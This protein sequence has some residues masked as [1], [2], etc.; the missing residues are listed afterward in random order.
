MLPLD[1][2]IEDKDFLLFLLL[3]F[4]EDSLLSLSLEDDA[5]DEDT[6]TLFLIT[7]FGL[8]NVFDS[9]IKDEDSLV[10]SWLFF[11]EDSLLELSLEVESSDDEKIPF[12]LPAFCKE[13]LFFLDDIDKGTFLLFSVFFCD[14]PILSLS[15]EIGF[16][17]IAFCKDFL[18][19]P[20][21]GGGIKD[22]G[23]F[24]LLLLFSS[25]SN[26][27]LISLSLEVDKSVFA[28]TSVRE[29]FLIS[30]HLGDDACNSFLLVAFPEDS[31]LLFELF[32]PSCTRVTTQPSLTLELE[33]PPS[34]RSISIFF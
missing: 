32:W 17:L 8:S 21:L 18:L 12:L 7:F 3:I 30:P 20:T 15:L 5:T 19:S 11:S 14:E 2:G 27:W 13:F 10:F 6:I 24:G 34:S 31:S 9:G 28:S 4:S 25:R 33:I 23:W 1:T 22:E 26:D 29:N 16:I